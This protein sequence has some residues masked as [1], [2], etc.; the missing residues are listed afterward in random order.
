MPE[1]AKLVLDD[2]IFNA[3]LP[4]FQLQ[5]YFNV[6]KHL[7]GL[8]S[9]NR[10]IESCNITGDSYVLD[11]GCGVGQ[12]ACYLAR[13]TGCRVAG[14]D[15]TEAMVIRAKERVV[16]GKFE[17]RVEIK[18]A[19]A[20]TLPYGDNIF[21]AVIT[22]SVIVFINDKQGALDEFKRVLKPGGHIGL[23]ETMLV[24]PSPPEDV[25][26]ALT[27]SE[28]FVAEV[29]T[30][31]R[32]EE[33]LKNAGF[34]KIEGFTHKIGIWGELVGHFKRFGIRGSLKS[35]SRSL[36]SIRNPTYRKFMKEAKSLPRSVTKYLG[37]GIYTGEK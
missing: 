27:D 25:I 7:G 36:G 34:Q 14:I 18:Q 16:K 17:D 10:L 22:E 3:E 37:Y 2:S 15:I 33:L 9:T 26:K 32:A 24:A 29:L 21:D 23:N 1:K 31:E 11:V 28:F 20:V 35:I 5:G 4:I 8:K 19:D 6:S 30:P 12:T 13:K